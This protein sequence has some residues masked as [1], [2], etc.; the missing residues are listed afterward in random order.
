M[1]N[2]GAT[3]NFACYSISHMSQYVTQYVVAHHPARDTT[4]YHSRHSMMLLATH[5]VA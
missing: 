1:V 4:Q 2:D 3:H 5:H